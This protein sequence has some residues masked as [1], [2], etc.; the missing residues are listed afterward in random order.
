MFVL[1][2]LFSLV[3]GNHNAAR[4]PAQ[5]LVSHSTGE[6]PIE[7]YIPY[8]VQAT[9]YCPKLR[10]TTA[11][12]SAEFNYYK[13]FDMIKGYIADGHQVRGAD[14]TVTFQPHDAKFDSVDVEIVDI[15]TGCIE[16]ICQHLGV[17]LP[18]AVEKMVNR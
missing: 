3:L 4:E 2:I 12:Q 14:F 9:S 7:Y 8:A 17:V 16:S 6:L 18:V 13:Y 11:V 15:N 5:P 10:D 1:D